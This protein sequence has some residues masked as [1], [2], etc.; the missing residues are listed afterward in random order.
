MRVFMIVLLVVL[1]VA[2]LMMATMIHRGLSAREQPTR[3]EEA[4]ARG[5]RRFAT[6]ASARNLRNPIAL[7]QNALGEARAHWA[8]HCATCHGNDGSGQ[9]EIGRNLYPKA[10]DM[11]ASRTQQLT[12]GELFSIIKNGVRL[13]GM[14]A[15]GDAAGRDDA[16]TWKLVHFIRHLPK[17]T[18][19][20]L[21]QMKAMNPITP[22]EMK[23]RENE[24]EFLRGGKIRE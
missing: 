13:T 21:E 12:D 22:A 23:E 14:P 16:G 2:G 15:W 20:E 17:I 11:R 4:I 8:D 24:D 7:D 6:P 3:M 18:P 5:M 10:P 9:T 19:A 1:I